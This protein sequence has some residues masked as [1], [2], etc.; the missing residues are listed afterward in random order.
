MMVHLKADKVSLNYPLIQRRWF[1]TSTRVRQKRPVGGRIET[2]DGKSVVHALHDVSFELASGHRLGLIGANGAGK[3][4]LLKV[5]YG[6]FPPTT[7][8]IDVS[9]SRDALFNIQLGFRREAT[10]RR[11]IELRGLINDWSRAEIRD[12]T[13]EI[14]AFSEIG[15]FIDMPLKLY[16]QGMAARLAFAIATSGKPDILLM[17]EW[18]GAGDAR[19]QKKAKLRMRER[20]KD[21]GIVV[22]ASHNAKILQETCTHG[23]VLNAGRVTFFGNLEDAL[24]HHGLAQME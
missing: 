13:E 19:F 5:L 6:I 4:T 17:D 14:I 23:L 2:V 12:R 18:I 9:G 3:S 8:T 15:E 7:G 10:G 20:L 21:S 11:N 24:E 16:S 22:L 1:S